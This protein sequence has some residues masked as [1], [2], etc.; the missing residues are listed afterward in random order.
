MKNLR[1]LPAVLAFSLIL[2]TGCEKETVDTPNSNSNLPSSGVKTGS[3]D[4][5][6][7]AEQELN[8]KLDVNLEF[9]NIV[10]P[11]EC[12]NTAFDYWFD[13]EL[14]DWTGT[15]YNYARLSLAMFDLPTYDALVFVN[16]SEGQYF[17]KDGEHTQIMTKTFKDLNRFW[18]ID[19]DDIV[20]GAMHGDMLQDRDKVI[21]TYVAAYGMPTATAEYY[22]DLVLAALD[23]YPEYRDGNH[24]I[25]TLNA[26]A[27]NS[28]EYPPY[29]INGV[30]PA[31]I[32]MGD[33]IVKGFTDL[34]FE[35]VAPQAILAH[36]YGHQIQFQRNVF[37]DG[38]RT[39]E[40]TRRTELMADALAAYYLSHARGATMQWKRVKQFLQVFYD[41]GDCGFSS[42]GHHGTPLQRMA[43]AEWGYKLADNA[44][45]QGKILS[46]EQFIQ[47]FDAKL[48]EL[49]AVP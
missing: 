28:F 39:A 33:G 38:P 14:S 4:Y 15:S 11:T 20:L 25:F 21:R 48:P 41:I 40:K 12:G 2:M 32:I 3:Q 5:E 7:S 30:I 44:K 17:G 13:D 46:S 37:D 6:K 27:Q 45:K 10:E 36:E 16:S 24:P 23:T 47:L 29:G 31:K 26:F 35:D 42:T 1:L 18:D 34:G 49:V 19:S 8:S 22:A 9:G 43:A